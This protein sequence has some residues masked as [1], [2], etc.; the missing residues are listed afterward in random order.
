M[1]KIKEKSKEAAMFM[2]WKTQHCGMSK[3]LNLMCR[4]TQFHS[5]S[6]LNRNLKLDLKSMCVWFFVC[7]CVS[8]YEER[9]RFYVTDKAISKRSNNDEGSCPLYSEFTS[10]YS[11]LCTRK[12]L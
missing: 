7:V 1:R 4:L 6:P 3:L 5:K 2:D 9:E 12:R 10:I 8:V 11:I